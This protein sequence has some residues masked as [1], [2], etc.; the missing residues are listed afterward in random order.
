MPSILHRLGR[1]WLPGRRITGD[2]H[3]TESEG[4]TDRPGEGA[5]RGAG[6]GVFP[7]PEE[8]G[9][10]QAAGEA[11]TAAGQRQDRTGRGGTA[12]GEGS[13][14]LAPG[15]R[16][17]GLRAFEGLFNRAAD[18]GPGPRAVR[19]PQLPRPGPGHTPRR[20]AER[21]WP[22][23]V[24]PGLTVPQRSPQRGSRTRSAPVGWLLLPGQE[25]PGRPA[26]RSGSTLPVG[27]SASHAGFCSGGA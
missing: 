10:S 24:A 19:Q 1:R 8:E 15:A 5:G 11:P 27:R 16:A 17:R 20:G 13:A 22:P 3:P 14:G 25:A 9:R 6:C 21:R 26:L 7:A 4:E 2:F 18:G 23:E 12:A